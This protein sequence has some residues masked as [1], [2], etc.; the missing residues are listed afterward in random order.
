[1]NTKNIF[2]GRKMKSTTRYVIAGL[3]LV[4][5]ITG[6]GA[7]DCGGGLQCKCGD[8]LT[9]PHTMWYDL[10][11]SG[12][13]I[14]IGNSYIN[15]DCS[16]HVINGGGIGYGIY[17]NNKN[18]NT[19]KN[20]IITG[21]DR[22]IYLDHSSSNTITNNT[23]D[24]NNRGIYLY[25]S[26]DNLIDNNTADSNTWDGIYLE[27]SSTTATG[28]RGI[29][30]QDRRM[31]CLANTTEAPYN[32]YDDCGVIFDGGDRGGSTCGLDMDIVF[33]M[34]D[35]DITCYNAE[36]GNFMEIKTLPGTCEVITD[37]NEIEVLLD[38][39]YVN[40]QCYL[41][42]NLSQDTVTDL[43]HEMYEKIAVN[44]DYINYY[45]EGI[46]D[47]VLDEAL[48]MAVEGDAITYSVYADYLPPAFLKN[49][50]DDLVDSRY[51]GKIIF[52]GDEYFVKEW[53][54]N[55]KILKLAKGAE[56]IINNQSYGGDFTAVDGT[57]QF[58]INE[59]LFSGDDITGIVIDVK[60][61]NG[62]EVQVTANTSVNAV[63]GQVEIYAANVTASGN[64]AG[65][66]VK[67]YDLSTEIELEDGAWFGEN[68]EWYVE[69]EQVPLKCLAELSTSTG[70]QAIDCTGLEPGLEEPSTGDRN[71]FED[72]EK[73]NSSYGNSGML[74]WVHL[75]LKT[76]YTEDNALGVGENIAFPLNS[77]LFTYEGYKTDNFIE[78]R[79]SGDEDKIEIKKDGDH[80]VLISFTDDNHDRYDNVHLDNGPI[81]EGEMFMFNGEVWEFAGGDSGADPSV[82]LK[83]MVYG[84]DYNVELTDDMSH[85]N[86]WCNDF[87]YDN[88][89][90]VD[91]KP[92]NLYATFSPVGDIIYDGRYLYLTQNNGVLGV[93]GNIVGYM[94]HFDV[95][96]NDLVISILQET[97][98]DLN[99]EPSYLENTDDVLIKIS[100]G[101][102]CSGDV[103]C[104]ATYIDFY[105]K[106]RMYDDDWANSVL[107]IQSDG[108]VLDDED[109]ADTLW[110]PN[111]GA[112]LVVDYGPDDEIVGVEICHPR[113][114]V[115]QT[116]SIS[117]VNYESAP[118][119][120]IRG[121]F[122]QDK[123]TVCLANTTEAPDNFYTG[124]GVIFDGGNE[125]IEYLDSTGNFREIK[126]NY[127]CENTKMDAIRVEVLLDRDYVNNQCFLCS[128][129]C[130][131]TVTDLE[132]EMYE[133]IAVNTDNFKYYEEGIDDDYLD[134]ALKLA[135]E[136]NSITYSVYA[137]YLPPTFL[138]NTDRDLVDSR[139]R[140]KMIFLGDE[141]FVKEWDD[142][143]EIL[144]LA[145]GAE[146]I[147]DN[148]AYGGDFTAG[149]GTYEFKVHRAIFSEDQVAGIVID[150]KK[151]D[152]TEVRVVAQRSLNA[153]VGNVEIYVSNVATAGDFVRADVKV[154]DLSTE[155]V[156]ED[157]E[158]FD[159][160]KQLWRVEIEKVPLG[161][162]V[163]RLSGYGPEQT[164]CY[165]PYTSQGGYVADR[166]SDY[167]KV[168]IEYESTGMLKW[169]H[170]ILE[171]SYTEGGDFDSLGVGEKIMF[172]LD[173]FRLS[174]EG[175]KTRRFADSR[176]SGGDDK[177]EIKKV[178]NHQVTISFTDDNRDR[179]DDVHL[180]SGPI[181]E[182]E[183]FMFNGEVW[184]FV[185]G[186]PG[187]SPSVELK[188]RITGKKWVVGLE[189]NTDP[190]NLW[191]NDFG[192]D[193]SHC[194]DN[195]PTNLYADAANSPVGDIIYDGIYLYLTANNGVLGMDPVVAGMLQN[196]DTD[197]NKIK[198]SIEQETGTDLNMEPSYLE[199]TDD[200]LIK[201][202]SGGSICMG[203]PACDATY[204][205]FYDKSRFYDDDWANSVL[206]IRSDGGVLDDEDD[207]D[208]LWLPNSGDELVVDY[209]ADDEIKG[210]TIC[211][212]RT[213]VYPTYFLGS[214]MIKT[215]HD[216]TQVEDS[217]NNF[218]M[219]NKLNSNNN[220]IYL[221]SSLNTT[222]QGN[223]I[224]DN[225]VGIY[226]QNSNSIINSNIVCDNNLDF[227]SPDWFSSY[228]DDNTCDLA[229]AWNDYGEIT[230]CTNS[231]PCCDNT[232]YV[233]CG[234]AYS[235]Y[236]G[237]TKNDMCG[238]KQYYR[239]TTIQTCD[240]T[241]TITNSEGV[242]YDLYTLDNGS[243]P[244]ESSWDCRPYSTDTQETC[245]HASLPPGTY[246][247]LAGNYEGNGTYNINVE[248]GNCIGQDGANITYTIS[249]NKV[250]PGGTASVNVNINSPSGV[251]SSQIKLSIP[252]D[253]TPGNA[254]MSGFVTGSNRM[255][256]GNEHRW[257]KL[258]A[259]GNNSGI[260]S[261]PVTVPSSASYGTQYT[262]NL[263]SVN[264]KDTNSQGIP[265]NRQIPITQTIEVGCPTVQDIFDAMDSYFNDYPSS[266]CSNNIC[267]VPDI[268]RMIDD[269]FAC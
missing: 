268:F 81:E 170:L 160:S 226:S 118:D 59:I 49:K 33:D 124:S 63:S 184:E 251:A 144:V 224:S 134:E 243:C 162:V 223:L 258:I 266:L 107:V 87:D 23:A 66:E 116:Y 199:N 263:T 145:K 232:S 74:K 236:D 31:V 56:R 237:E 242:D 72:Y 92:T 105:D 18:N 127:V 86:L 240:I 196:F 201:I 231:C 178:G 194:V 7:K 146:R 229:D 172:P 234:S 75:T 53:D 248:I 135:V 14:V 88:T 19:I 125:T 151:P 230:G 103:A 94:T 214:D 45:E 76:N 38:R 131:D 189:E 17:L 159:D 177:I 147:L 252:P 82:E 20:C 165:S 26:S 238:D 121:I 143:E 5:L 39:D 115:Y 206:V 68:Q 173:A 269:Y 51:R 84:E 188:N 130:Q 61:P 109:D 25:S 117:T 137:D 155:I 203:D 241:W 85:L 221:D 211:H 219:N 197:N 261:V 182:G 205:D 46:G 210:V 141:Y 4:S 119:T 148:Y 40:N 247:A 41:C 122:E 67:V 60:K 132:H 209:G 239:I 217:N 111:S 9:S 54:D 176:C 104:D 15:L 36:T 185:E 100:S 65:A 215:L 152:G 233:S 128:D 259:N 164:E 29:L 79:C 52:L 133:Q 213:R 50:D 64:I 70:N 257:F 24:S 114:M 95:D 30:N 220:G 208:T 62:T 183:L 181:M 246:Y 112:E 228:G 156:L 77:F 43:E 97:G 250:F 21:F 12:N 113:T 180:D 120:I 123:R 89:H 256:T 267:T 48:K 174:Y 204:I 139:Y 35:E 136:G 102:L 83:R 253:L 200:T 255:Q 254:V 101:G 73:I 192:D 166:F 106:Y 235:M 129:I 138:K 110:L 186:D 207:A 191:C 13:G 187:V 96:D 157:G 149:D 169:V 55:N 190:L 34:G 69:I 202:S 245:F 158:W 28:Y 47:D 27:S 93:N 1:M 179:Y 80:Q 44:K 142:E 22:G 244:S 153:V 161:C 175:Y 264:I 6:A 222:L 163:D 58:K 91:N 198:I 32:F 262:I 260:L 150:V 167:E 8:T 98:T 154:Y 78:P 249:S 57:Y 10:N 265:L 218:I 71:R 193:N 168:S 140:G 37:E 225:M 126:T 227:N 11:C 195:E 216:I 171:A 16:G 108:G 99:N 42:Y 3:I 90:C 2:Y 212:P